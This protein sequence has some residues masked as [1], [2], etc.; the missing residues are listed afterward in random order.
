VTISADIL[1]KIAAINHL[2]IA[3]VVRLFLTEA[4]SEGEWDMTT[5]PRAASCNF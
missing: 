1:K 2:A 3:E 4:L 5:A